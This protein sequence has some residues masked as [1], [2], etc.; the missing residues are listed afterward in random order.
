[1]L[2]PGLKA[3][4]DRATVKVTVLDR[5]DGR[6]AAHVNASTEGFLFFSEPS[7]PERKATIDGHSVPALKANLA[8]TAVAVPA[9]EH[10]VE[11]R[12]SPSRFYLGALISSMTAFGYAF[13]FVRRPRRERAVT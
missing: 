8:F 6:V 9:G 12:Y 4:A 13:T 10:S 11:L 3:C 5:A 7:Y 1:M 2:L